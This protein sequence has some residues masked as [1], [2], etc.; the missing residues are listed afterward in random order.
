M[1]VGNYENVPKTVKHRR[2]EMNTSSSVNRINENTPSQ[3]QTPSTST[4]S[5]RAPSVV[6]PEWN[7]DAEYQSE[8]PKIISRKSPPKNSDYSGENIQF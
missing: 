3:K 5:R 1:T 6:L 8:A 4:S 7:D 2:P